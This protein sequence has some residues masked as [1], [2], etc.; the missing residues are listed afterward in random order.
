VK[1]REA[2]FRGDF[3]AI[4]AIT[5]DVAANTDERAIEARLLRSRALLKL[6]RPADVLAELHEPD[7]AAIG[8]VDARCI[9]GVLRA[10]T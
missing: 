8:D 5:A 4:I 2:Y 10:A 7:L 6:L 1:A 3:S 9:T